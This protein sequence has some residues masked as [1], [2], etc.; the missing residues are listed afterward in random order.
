GI[1][2]FTP[3]Q[4]MEYECRLDSRDPDAWLE[5]MNPAM[6]S[7]LATGL[8]T[9]EVRAIAGEIG[10]FEGD[11]TPARYTWRVGPHPDGPSET[12]LDCDQANITLT[13]GADGWA[14][15]V[16]PIEN[17]VFE[18]ELEVRSAADGG[19]G[20]P[21]VPQN[22]RAFFRF[23]IVND[24][25]HCV[26]ESATL[27]LYA[28][29]HTEA[30]TLVAVPLEDAW[31]ESSL[32]WANQPDPYPGA[33]AATTESGEHYREWDV[34][35][36]VEAIRTGT[37]PN[38]GW[39]IRDQHESDT[40]EGGDQSFMSREMPQDPPEVTLP[41]L[42]LRYAAV[43]SPPPA[44]PAEPVGETIVHC[45]QVITESTRLAEDVTGCLGEGIAIGAPN[46]VL[47]LNGHTISS[48]MVLE[49]GEEDFL[50]PGVR[51]GYPNVVIRNGVVTNYGYGVLLGPGSTHNVV[52][53]LTL[54]RNALAGVQLFDADNG[55]TGS[56]IRN[57][58]FDSNGETGLQLIAGSEGSTVEN[59][60]FVSNGMS[61]HLDAARAN[62][63]RNNEIS[64]IIIDPELDS[65]AGI[66]LENGSRLNVLESNDVSDTG[67]AGIVIH[68]GSHGNRV[69]G[70]VLVRNGDAGVIVQDSDRIEIDGVLAHRQSDGGVVLSNSSGS[71]VK[72]SDLGY[73]PAGIE[74]SHTNGLLVDGN[75]A[76]HSL[77]SGIQVGEGVGMR[78]TNNAANLT[79]GSGI[80]VEA[81]TFD[82]LGVAVGGAL[83]ADNTT[84]E[85]AEN[86]ITVA[87]NGRHTLARNTA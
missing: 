69:L 22:A 33:F 16:N 24:A 85:N 13:A 42:E 15:Q 40:L 48:G 41:E 82:S 72:N 14:D 29:G 70:G 86:G 37:L 55:R 8:H 68:Q 58:R 74:A 30:R 44:P 79:G 76:S 54:Y 27:R 20:E 81:G 66:V 39:V 34:K 11:P 56:L 50:M 71:S 45:G 38:N 28:G 32:T 4:F 19:E 87:D 78:I 7:N 83:I 46:I 65:D 64:G 73:N 63:I 49:P 9:F 52:E 12:P 60:Y 10:A 59:N 77:Q 21:I 61:I 47:D 2:D 43:G 5:C 57:N 3:P 62:V 23:P 80:S 75:D 51:S 26:L 18:T 6:Y 67:D 25:P 84:N 31:K 53:G 17:Y 1:S 36:H 35:A